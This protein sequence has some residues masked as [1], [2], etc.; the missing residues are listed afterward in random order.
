VDSDDLIHPQ[1]LELLYEAAMSGDAPIS[2]CQMLEAE[3]LPEDFCNPLESKFEVL[4]MDEQTLLRLHDADAYPAWVACAKLIRRD[5]VEAYPFREGRVFEDNEAVCRWVCGGKKLATMDHKLY[6]YRTNQGSTTKSSFSIKK[7]DYLWALESIIRYY[8]SLGF[9]QMRQ[10]FL[11]RY[12][13]AV[14][15]SCNGLRYMLGQEAAVKD[16]E[17]Q[18]RKFAGEQKLK[19]TQAQIEALLDATHPKLIKLYWP[20]AAAAR[21]LREQGISGMTKKITERIRKGTQ[22]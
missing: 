18:F 16:V 3:T 15:S 10:R 17:K 6:F 8:S 21:I 5:L 12:V 22:K 2:M 4:T 1:M 19:L 20:A 9:E 11:T 14:V 13:D 7:L